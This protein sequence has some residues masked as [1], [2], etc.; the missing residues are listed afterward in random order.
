MGVGT[1][2]PRRRHF[3]SG[4]PET[5]V[6]CSRWR[7]A[8]RRKSSPSLC[9]NPDSCLPQLLLQPLP[10]VPWS[11][12]AAPHQT[13][14]SLSRRRRPLSLKRLCHHAP[15]GIPSLDAET[16][17]PGPIVHVPILLLDPRDCCRTHTFVELPCSKNSHGFPLLT[18]PDPSA[19]LD[20]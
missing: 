14:Q 19:S 15:T 4:H 3:T 17:F 12:E 11:F 1:A 20:L 8:G 7:G 9:P 6:D 16:P 10:A 5:G 18:P 2:F 13:S